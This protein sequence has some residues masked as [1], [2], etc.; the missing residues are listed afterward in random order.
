[1][2]S[3]HVSPRAARVWRRLSEWYGARLA[4]Q[5]GEDP[6]G[7]WCEIVDR[8]DNGTIKAGL[9]KIRTTYAAHP[10]TLPQFEAA[11]RPARQVIEVGPSNAE[12][13]AV[14]A[15][16]QVGRRLTH[17]QLRG[18]WSYGGERFATTNAKGEIDPRGGARVT[19]VSIS[20][21]G[22]APGYRFTL[23]DLAAD[24]IEPMAA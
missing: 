7:D 14:F 11:M 12:R 15:M 2:T 13:L 1:M 18:P 21:D 10:P 19:S 20:P 6:P 8:A 24:E 22:D 4:D 16:R 5:F 17:K 23:D 3:R 9:V